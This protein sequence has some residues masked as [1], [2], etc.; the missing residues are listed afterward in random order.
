MKTTKPKN[1][2][3][4][5]LKHKD[6]IFGIRLSFGG[7]SATEPKELSGEVD[8]IDYCDITSIDLRDDS[9]YFRIS[10]SH[11]TV[12]FGISTTLYKD[13]YIDEHCYLNLDTMKTGY[14]GFYTL[15]PENWKEDLNRMFDL[16]LKKKEN[17]YQQELKIYQDKFNLFMDSEQKINNVKF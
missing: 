15:K 8:V 9:D 5:S 6:K 4:L 2:S 17:Q 13:H 7:H 12:S 3:I 10:I 14:D 11:P 16:H 1:G